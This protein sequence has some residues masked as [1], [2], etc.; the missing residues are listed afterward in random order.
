MWEIRDIESRLFACHIRFDRPKRKQVLWWRNGSWR[1]G[2]VTL[3][4]APLYR[5]DFIPSFSK[6]RPVWITEGE[7]SADALVSAL[8]WQVLATVTGASALPHPK[9]LEPL[10]ELDV[11]LWPDQDKQGYRHMKELRELLFPIARSVKERVS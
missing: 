8:E 5:T 2:D 11:C 7:K 3:K 4:Q 1:L 6:D 10:R 9:V